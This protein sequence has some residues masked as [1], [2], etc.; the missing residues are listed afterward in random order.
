MVIDI[1]LDFS[2]LQKV[3]RFLV[4]YRDGIGSCLK[5]TWEYRAV[6]V[7]VIIVLVAC[8]ACWGVYG[9]AVQNLA[10]MVPQAFAVAI[11]AVTLGI[12]LVFSGLQAAEEYWLRITQKK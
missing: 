10:I 6:S 9:M 11:G 7:L 8:A 2:P 5:K 3:V 4:R 1:L 12:Y